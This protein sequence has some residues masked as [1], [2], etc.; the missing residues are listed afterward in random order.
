MPTSRTDLWLFTSVRRMIRTKKR[1]PS[2]RLVSP[3]APGRRQMK[4]VCVRNVGAS[5]KN[6]PSASI[7]DRPSSV[8][9]LCLQVSSVRHRL[10]SSVRCLCLQVSSVRHRL[11]STILARSGSPLN[12]LTTS[13]ASNSIAVLAAIGTRQLNRPISTLYVKAPE[14]GHVIA[15]HARV[16]TVTR[17]SMTVHAYMCFGNE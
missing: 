5:I 12:L 3:T 13:T 8:Q 17:Q 1:V 16:R 11:P 6:P 7:R 2:T 14:I 15:V 9:C 4:P 10:P